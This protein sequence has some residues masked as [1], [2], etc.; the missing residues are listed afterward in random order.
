LTAKNLLFTA[1]LSGHNCHANLIAER[2]GAA[3]PKVADRF[4]AALA[5]RDRLQTRH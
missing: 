5:E 4:T 3:R 1:T 2:S